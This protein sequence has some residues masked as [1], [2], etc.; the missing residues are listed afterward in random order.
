MKYMN[1]PLL[2]AT[3]VVNYTTVLTSVPNEIYVPT[4]Q[5]SDSLSNLIKN[6]ITINFTFSPKRIE[7]ADD[8]VIIPQV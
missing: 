8:L 3:T 5:K 1:T 2:P 4:T 6:N 7:L